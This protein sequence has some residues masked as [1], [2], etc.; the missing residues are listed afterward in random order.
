[1]TIAEN[2]LVR[3]F[4]AALPDAAT[5][6]RIAAAADSL[7]LE[8][9]A[10]RVPRD[11]YHVTLA[12]IG[13][14]AA[15]RLPAVLAIGRARQTAAFSLRLD[16]YEYWPKPEVVVA[17]A[18]AIPPALERLWQE[19]HQELASHQLALA[20]KRLRPHVTLARKVS[21]APVPQ[22]MSGLDW[23]VR[24]FCLMRSDT[25]GARPAYT[26]VGTWPLLD[27]AAET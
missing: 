8:P 9:D 4:F 24:D 25:A 7:Q 26:V 23:P 20:P 22:A 2:S 14:I 6:L 11:N 21:Q 15:S 17:A 3:L 10:Q 27:D 1:V 13:E 5:R 12:F 18:R 16:A 19:L